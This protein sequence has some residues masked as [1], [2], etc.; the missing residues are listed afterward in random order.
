MLPVNQAEEDSNVLI[1]S[2]IAEKITPPPPPMSTY[3]IFFIFWQLNEGN[4]EQF[5]VL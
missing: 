4:E 2:Q 1:L 5:V 3:T